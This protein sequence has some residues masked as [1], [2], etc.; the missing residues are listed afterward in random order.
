[1]QLKPKESSPYSWATQWSRDGSLSKTMR[2]TSETWTSSSF[3]GFIKSLNAKTGKFQRRTQGN[4]R[5]SRG[6]L[7]LH[8]C[9]LNPGDIRQ[10]Q[11][12][13][14]ITIVFHYHTINRRVEVFQARRL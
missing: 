9:R 5:F 11:P 8:C 2:W 10:E 7:H 3:F 4:S 12:A 6:N 1:M 14:E 13:P